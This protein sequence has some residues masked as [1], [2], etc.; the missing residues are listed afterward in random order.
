MGLEYTTMIELL[1]NMATHLLLKWMVN[2]KNKDISFT[3]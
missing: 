3:F 1:Q 2:Y